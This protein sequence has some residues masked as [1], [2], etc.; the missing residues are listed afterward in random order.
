MKVLKTAALIGLVIAAVVIL[1][2]EPASGAGPKP[3]A[4][5]ASATHR[6]PRQR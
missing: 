5:T 4:H 6:V 1:W 3:A 2:L